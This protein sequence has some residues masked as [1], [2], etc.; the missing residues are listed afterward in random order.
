LDKD[1]GELAIVRGF[2]HCGLLRIANFMAR[3][4]GAV[5]QQVLEKHGTE[6]QSGAVITAEPGRLRIRPPDTPSRG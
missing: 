4:Q 3:M 2:P 6:L 1:F 5:I